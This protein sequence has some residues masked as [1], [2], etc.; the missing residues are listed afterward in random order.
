MKV[1][2]RLYFH[3]L[4][5][6]FKWDWKCPSNN[7]YWPRAIR[8]DTNISTTLSMVQGTKTATQSQQN[9]S[10]FLLPVRRV[11]EKGDETLGSASPFRWNRGARRG[12]QRSGGRDPLKFLPSPALNSELLFNYKTECQDVINRTEKGKRKHALFFPYKWGSELLPIKVNQIC[13]SQK[14]QPK[15]RMPKTLNR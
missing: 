2:H 5:I 10:F 9:L 6:F 12:G 15:G 8:M 1:L 13:F 11:V 3:W 4:S 7:T 14:F